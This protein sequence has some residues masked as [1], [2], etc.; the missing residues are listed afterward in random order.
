VWDPA[1]NEICPAF[2]EILVGHVDVKNVSATQAHQ[3]QRNV[4]ISSPAPLPPRSSA[5]R[6]TRLL[7]APL[8]PDISF[9]NFTGHIM[10]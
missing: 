10:C 2:N 1:L 4:P 8:R 5:H 7:T 3:M 6:V 9:A